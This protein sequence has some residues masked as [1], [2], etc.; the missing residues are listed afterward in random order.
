MTVRST[1]APAALAIALGALVACAPTGLPFGDDEVRRN[2][3]GGWSELSARLGDEC[4]RC[5][6]GRLTCDGPDALVCVG[7]AVNA[8]GGCGTLGG[9][10]GEACGRCDGT[11]ECDGTDLVCADG[12]ANACGGCEPLEHDPGTGC[13]TCGE[14]WT[15]GVSGALVCPETPN[16]CGGC[17]KLAARPGDPCGECAAGEFVCDGIDRIRCDAPED[18]ANACGGC[19]MLAADPGKPCGRCGIWECAGGDGVECVEGGVLACGYADLDGDGFG[20]GESLCECGGGPL[21]LRPGDCDDTDADARPICGDG[22]AQCG[23][24]VGCAFRPALDDAATVTPLVGAERTASLRNPVVADSDLTGDGQVDLAIAMPHRPC[25]DQPDRECGAIAVL[26]GPISGFK[27]AY[28]ALQAPRDRAEVFGSCLAAG[29]LDADGVDDLVVVGADRGGIVVHVF[30]GPVAP[31]SSLQP[32]QAD[33]LLRPL[34]GAGN[35]VASC[36]VAGSDRDGRAV[37]LSYAEPARVDALW[38]DGTADDVQFGVTPGRRVVTDVLRRPD[39]DLLYA[40]NHAVSGVRGEVHTGIRRWT[41]TTILADVVLLERGTAPMARFAAAAIDGPA[42]DD[43][44]GSTDTGGVRMHLGLLGVGE[45]VALGVVGLGVEDGDGWPVAAGADLDGDGRPEIVIGD[46]AGSSGAGGVV[47]GP[48]PE[49]PSDGPAIFRPDQF[50]LIA[51]RQA[52]AALGAWVGMGSDL[53]GDGRG[54]LVVLA[55]GV[56]ES[57]TPTLAIFFARVGE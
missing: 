25:A 17:M 2:P 44:I 28:R 55:P 43:A 48:L 46:P 47:W 24:D 11:W 22:A 42:W 56:E 35:T 8:C 54:D 53:D 31:S 13:G 26:A 7:D 40:V 34:D 39:G 6:D 33:V 1:I 4:G 5:G 38:L 29:D 9:E 21:A 18:W 3:C 12:A 20:T 36:H 15:C 50:G 32:D 51:G 27:L 30:L 16:G 10:P 14:V 49:S 52:D 37:V 19:A 23:D 45:Q 41:P 57:P